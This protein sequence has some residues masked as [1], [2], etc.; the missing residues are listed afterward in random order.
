MRALRS[1]ETSETAN[2]ATEFYISDD[3]NP[4]RSYFFYRHSLLADYHEVSGLR[5]ADP[6]FIENKTHS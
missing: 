5:Q 3:L 2:T 4:L 6:E 1:F